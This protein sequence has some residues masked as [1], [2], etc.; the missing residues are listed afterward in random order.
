LTQLLELISFKHQ[1]VR[2]IVVSVSLKIE[3]SQSEFHTAKP[4]AKNGG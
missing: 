2:R 3:H 4:I 1:S